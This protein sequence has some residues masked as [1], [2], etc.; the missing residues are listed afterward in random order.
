MKRLPLLSSALIF[1]VASLVGCDSDSASLHFDTPQ[2]AYA[3]FADA[4][5]NDDWITA[6]KAL[7][8]DS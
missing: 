8:Y 4:T 6:T 3:A 2:D 5:K 7:N 1:A